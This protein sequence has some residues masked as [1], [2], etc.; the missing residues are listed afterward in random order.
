MWATRHIARK[1]LS[2]L[3]TVVF[4]LALQPAVS[5]MPA[6]QNAMSHSMDCCD[7]GAMKDHHGMPQKGC[8]T[9]CK[10]MANCNGVQSCSS[11]TAVQL[12]SAAPIAPIGAAAKPWQ[13][14]SVGRGITLR[15]DNPPP[16][17]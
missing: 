7:H 16:I 8:D 14:F 3:L 5:A 13:E 15:P 2:V 6:H 11:I 4:A 17:V 1:A 10:D 12:V 9:P